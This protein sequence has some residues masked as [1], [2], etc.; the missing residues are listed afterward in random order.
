MNVLDAFYQTVHAA[1]GGCEALAVR[2][3]MSAA[4]LRNKANPN[5]AAN[6][7]M[8]EEVD[9]IMGITSDHQILHALARNHGYVCVKVDDTSTASDMAV[10][11]LVT[12]VWSTQG[13][14]GA[15]ISAVLADG[16]V[17]RHELPGVRAKVFRAHRALQ[18]LT[19]RLDGMAEK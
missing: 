15:E 11:E 4:V 8:L 17:E 9:R 14:V 18:D 12:Q 7:P 16:R 10:L 1:P 19:A 6:K 2:L 5:A 3:G 13:E